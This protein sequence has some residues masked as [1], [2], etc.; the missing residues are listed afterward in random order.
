MCAID[1]LGAG[2]MYGE[3]VTIVSACGLC[4]GHFLHRGPV[5]L[6]QRASGTM[7]GDP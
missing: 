7:A 2:D 1:A 6:P 3:N 4:G 5:F